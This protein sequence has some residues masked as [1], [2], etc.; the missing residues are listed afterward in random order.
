MYFT[1]LGASDVAETK[2]QLIL[3]KS[4]NCSRCCFATIYLGNRVIATVYTIMCRVSEKKMYL[5]FVKRKLK[6]T[7][8][9]FK[10]LN[11]SELGFF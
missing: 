8:L 5:S 6:T 10:I 7:S 3:S 1:F 4:K 2:S 11:F 9:I